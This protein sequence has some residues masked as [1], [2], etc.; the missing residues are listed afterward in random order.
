MDSFGTYKIIACMRATSSDLI[1]SSILIWGLE[2]Q[3]IIREGS[4]P[5][6]FSPTL[7][8]NISSEDV[9]SQLRV[10]K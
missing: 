7:L 5:F 4:I 8:T 10:R 2:L 9:T 3:R 1:N 6:Q